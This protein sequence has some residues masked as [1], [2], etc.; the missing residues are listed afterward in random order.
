[1]TLPHP[2]ADQLE[3]QAALAGEYSIQRELGR[4]GMGIVYLARD[5][6]LDRDVAIK[7]LPTH[8]ARTGESRDRFLREARTAAGL[9][10][11]HIVP[12]H[13]VGEAGGFVF[14]VMSYVEGETLG[15]RLR[16]RG[17][18]PPAEAA[19][20]L[21]E[22]A[23]AL[24]YAHGRGIVHRDIKP[25]NIL[26]E[27]G[28]GRALVTD[29]GIAYGGAHAGPTTDP[30]KIMGTAHFMSPE[31][32]GSEAIDGR[33]DLYS[34]GV[35]GYLAVSGRLPFEAPSLPA[36]ILRQ[37][38]ETPTSVMRVAPGLPPALGAAIDRCLAR[39]PAGRFPDGEALAAALAPAPDARPALPPTLRAWLAARNPLLVPYMGWSAG[40]TVL[41]LG[42]VYAN[43]TG[44]PGSSWRDVVLLAAIA[45]APLFPIVG[46]HLNQA[47][48]QFRAG[49]SLADL[50]S[51]M[52]VERRER[53][54]TEALARGDE[55]SLAHRLLRIGTV[56]A[57]TWLG[58]TFVLVVDG[59]LHENRTPIAWFLTPLLLTMLLGALSNALD[60]QFIPRKLREWWQTGIRERLWN[61]RAGEWLAR[62]LGA[63]ERSR[64]VGVGAFRATEVALGVAAGELFAALPQPFREQLPEL[65]A[66]VAALEARAA[67]AR[68][69]LDVVAALAPSGSADAELLAGRRGKAA[70]RLADSVAALERIRL[71]LLRLHAG[72]D[73][74]APLTTLMDAARARSTRTWADSPRR[75]ARWTRCSAD[76]PSAP[77][78]SRRRRDAD[79]T[80]FERR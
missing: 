65:P 25:D 41:T 58:V 54:E 12:I 17:P 10:H 78:G 26:L 19:R 66:T 44:N 48:R 33:S 52:A 80:P 42:N 5:V 56:A 70:E 77:G 68:A 16:T 69:E 1:M 47:R 50:R 2:P 31:Q 61:S 76:G 11:P 64:E 9:S 60:V 14:F 71:D 63:P 27:A 13:R 36:L 75:S 62:R 35:V 24:A 49:H 55:E 3:L 43:A 20:V 53:A 6:Q 30:G 22:V 37:A 51:A 38:T 73:D 59:T 18:L 8:L 39:D 72:A 7:V 32:T 34:L 21:R 79:V 28:T 67:E 74:L 4:G 29:F 57:A 46:F 40:F 45:S 23:W 15:E